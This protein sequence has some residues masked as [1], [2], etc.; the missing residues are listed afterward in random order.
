MRKL[1]I[2][3]QIKKVAK[4]DRS[5]LAEQNKNSK[6]SCLPL[7]VTYNRTLPNIKNIL[8]QHW[9]LLKIDPTL[10]ETFQ[11]NPILAFC[12]NWNLKDIGDNKIEF[13]KVKQ[14]SLFQ[15]KG[16]CMLCLSNNRTLC[17]R[18]II[19]TTAFQINQNK[20]TY[21]IYHNLN[22]KSKYT[23]CLVECMKWNLQ[24][25]GKAETE[26]NQRINNHRKDN[27][28][29]NAIPADQHFAER[30]HDLNTD[31]EFTII[32]KPQNTKLSKESITELLKSMRTFG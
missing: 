3:N 18:Q 13:N 26:L 2:E 1:L 10:E 27:L 25:V 20:R 17:C 11:Q 7:W 31:T 6:A 29:L 16:T 15:T 21:R 24:Y 23:I 4:L 19:K 14:K 28:K 5:V 32:E 30:D 12:R 9:N 8:Q 22:C